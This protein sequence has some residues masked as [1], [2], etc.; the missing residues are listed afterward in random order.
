MQIVQK[1]KACHDRK[2]DKF[3]ELAVNGKANYI[4]TSDQDLLVLNP[5]Q[6]IAI[7]S[8]SDYLSL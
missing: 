3:L 1:I 8:V 7:I 4:I 2:D 6:D 5:F